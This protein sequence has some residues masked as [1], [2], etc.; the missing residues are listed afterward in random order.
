M[1]DKPTRAHRTDALSS[2][3]RDKY[4]YGNPNFLLAPVDPVLE[5]ELGY[6]WERYRD[7]A[8]DGKVYACMERRLNGVLGAETVVIPGSA[9]GMSPMREER[10]MAELLEDVLKHIGGED[11]SSAGQGAPAVT[12]AAFDGGFEALQ[13]YVL[14]AVLMGF[15]VTE[16]VW[17]IDGGFVY[18]EKA[19]LIDQAYWRFDRQHRLRLVTGNDAAIEG[20]L[21]PYRKVLCHTFGS[22]TDPYGLGLGNR[23]FW[24]VWFKRKSLSFWLRFLDKWS[25][26]TVKATA[27]QDAKPDEL[28]AL[29]ATA[30]SAQ[31]DKAIV[32]YEGEQIELLQ[33]IQ[34]AAQQGFDQ[35]ARF[36]DG[37]ISQ[38]ILGVTLTTDVDKSGKDGA[39]RDHAAKEEMVAHSDALRLCS[40][41][42]RTLSV[43]V[44]DYNARRE[45]T[46]APIIVK[47]F[48]NL[49]M[50]RTLSAVDV[51]LFQTGFQRTLESVNEAYA[52]GETR[53]R[54]APA[55]GAQAPTQNPAQVTAEET[56]R[57]GGEA[58]GRTRREE[59]QEPEQRAR[60]STVKAGTSTQTNG[61]I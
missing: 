57:E 21:V 50:L 32:V 33:A 4:F 28:Q 38:A 29:L 40:F 56:G 41:L 11:P 16:L 55:R 15:S 12:A 30:K 3:V 9:P 36:L 22:G 39:S 13:T 31:S 18:P 35:I 19:K 46:R 53:Y 25:G 51:N 58:S 34:T 52:H 43:W 59:G 23:L 49:D 54:E 44:R 60:L 24:P 48:P 47:R 61:V 26:P 17:Q 8:R 14:D 10:K 42:T 20:R 1:P 7:L 6:A 5:R 2:A 27:P 37:Q 45:S